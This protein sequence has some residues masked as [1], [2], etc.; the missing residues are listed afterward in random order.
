MSDSLTSMSADPE[1]D[2]RLERSEVLPLLRW[3]GS[4]KRQFS[5]LKHYFPC[6]YKCYVEP[7][8]GSAAFFFRMG[9]SR[10]RLN[11]INKNVIEFYREVQI[12][13]IDFY[14]KF[15]KLLRNR[16]NY[17]LVREEFKALKQSRKKSI[18]FY[19]LNR[20]CFNGIYR[21]N[22]AGE[23]NVPFSND[24]VS[25]YLDE[26]QFLESTLRL[27][28]ADITNLDFEELCNNFAKKDDFFYLDPPYYREGC[29]I[30]NEYN[31]RPFQQDDIARLSLTLETLQR[32]GANFLLSFARTKE[33]ETLAARWNSQAKRVTRSIAGNPNKRRQQVE[34][35][36]YNYDT[37]A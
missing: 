17:Y 9:P 26:Q 32:K 25:P 20:N 7:F 24:R 30:F 33:A 31:A 6:H 16:R 27:S 4:K 2:R 18:Y 22:K 21:T 34:L 35:L 11:D 1:D 15:R 3:A 12:E 28:K 23:F 8:A 29:R 19:Y 13:P 14:R 36:I 5:S 37:N 10:A